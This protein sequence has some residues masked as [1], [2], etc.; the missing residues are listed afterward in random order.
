MFGGLT[1]QTMKVSIRFL[2]VLTLLV[3][4]ISQAILQQREINRLQRE[5]QVQRSAQRRVSWIGPRPNLTYLHYMNKMYEQVL[6]DCQRPAETYAA[7][8]Q[9]F[10]QLIPKG[11]Q[12]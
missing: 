7:A 11:S 12:K 9:R 3:A 2:L 1:Q 4:L 10:R 6:A 5:L 8:H